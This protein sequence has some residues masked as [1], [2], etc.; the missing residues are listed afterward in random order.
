MTNDFIEVYED[1]LDA[2]TCRMLIERF[3]ASGKAVRGRTGGGVDTRLKDSWD[4]CIDDHAEWRDAVNRLNTVMMGALMRYVRKYPYTALAPLSLRMPDP[5]TGE[6]VMLDPDGIRALP[7]ATLQML[8]VKV[9]RPGT[10][11]L[12]KY[13]ADQGGY[14]YWHC[15]LYPKAGD[16]HG[17]TLHRVVL[18][19]IYLNDA[20]A[21][22]ETEFFHQQRKIVP[23]TGSLLIAPAGYTHTHRGNMPKGGDKYIATSWVL[24]QRPEVLF[25]AP[26]TPASPRR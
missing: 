14:P 9:F 16:T 5:A 20:F 13:V 24:F 8:M 18:W 1:A 4:I 2:A 3:N 17:E 26:P 15:E 19:S 12:Q 23:Q 6:L 10:I 22:G 25:A 11:N 7:D 21:E